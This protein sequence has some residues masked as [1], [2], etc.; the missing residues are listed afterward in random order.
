METRMQRLLGKAN[1][2]P[3]SPGVY[4]M[5]DKAGKVIYV[6]KSRKLKNRVAQYFQNSE[7]N[8]KTMKMVSLVHDFDYFLCDT[9]IEALTLENRMI[10][11]YSPKYN[12][13]LKDSKSYPYIKVTA[14]EY[15][16]IVYT[17]KRTADKG[18]RYFG[19]YS[20]TGTVFSVINL[21]QKTLGIPSCKRV[22]PRDIG[23]ERPCLYYQ[24]GQC[25]GV[26]TGKVSP[27][28]YGETIKCALNILRG[29][30]SAARRELEEQMM[31]YAEEEKYE[32]AARC[33]DALAALRSLSEKQKV[34]AAPDADK[35]VFALYTDDTCSCV[36]VFNIREG[37]VTDKE[38]FYFG[39]DQIADATTMP[40]FIGD[41][42]LKRE[43]VPHE[44]LLDF[45]IEDEDSE[46]LTEYLSD[47]AG[48]KAIIRTP[49]KGDM[50]TLCR[51][52]YANA[53]DKAKLYRLNAEKDEG[54]LVLLASML[55]LEVLPERIEAYDISNIGSENKTCGMV[56]CKD[57][58]FR[59]SDYRSFTIKTVDG[60][61]DYASMREALSRRLSHL[62]D[63]SG[64][65]SEAPDLILLD[66]G[67]GHVSTVRALM[68]EMGIDIPVFGMV[69]DDFH[70]TRALCDDEREISIAR[71]QSVFS[72]VYKIQEEVHRYSVSR[73]DT[74]KRKTLT[75]S[76]LEKINGIGKAKAKAL[77]TYFGGLSRVRTASRDELASVSGISAR[78]AD[79]I[80]KYFHGDEK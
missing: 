53:R 49:E 43:Y 28:E 42:Y 64:S 41:Y 11:Q 66:G 38:E 71:E 72:L 77:L 44:I 48:R 54:V 20:G 60:V 36:S 45:E 35:D 33:R 59:R 46:M 69:K 30:T 4:I 73:M 40:S 80:Y 22:F 65:F 21:L 32:V 27:E 8:L 56:V 74:A 16:Q 2:L 70:K 24:M 67:K 79:N 25:L 29:N 50:R 58:K 14:G 23:K 34:V 63:E 15:P 18:A 10:K 3:L 12:I 75:T 1:T 5:K 7:K 47:M 55:R 6:G 19:P 61:D 39:A 37:A 26:C 57:G 31:R 51:M 9:E 52:V 68:R 17:R 62:A 76:S 13:R 78:D